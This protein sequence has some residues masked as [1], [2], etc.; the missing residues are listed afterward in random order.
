MPRRPPGG[1]RSSGGHPRRRQPNPIPS[2]RE[3]GGR[4]YPAR[5]V[6]ALRPRESWSRANSR[7]KLYSR[8]AR[9]VAPRSRVASAR[10]AGGPRAESGSVYL[11]DYESPLWEDY[12]V[13]VVPTLALFRGGELVD[14]EVGVLGYGVDP[15]RAGAVAA[16]V[17]PR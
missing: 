6:Y 1:R 12:D 16:R 11:D 14:R 4:P 10:P 8:Q 7:T 15:A 3:G 17:G 13:S 5:G 2:L 9:P